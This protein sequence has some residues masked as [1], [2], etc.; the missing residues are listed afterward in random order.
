MI[1]AHSSADRAAPA[2]YRGLYKYLDN[3][4]A[5]TV[6]LTFEQIESLLGFA[7]PEL[8]RVAQDWWADGDANGVR[9]TQSKSWGDASRSATAN[10]LSRSVVFERLP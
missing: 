1:D 2:E 3:R 4:F 9:S 6:V 5:D 8:A 7:L 10:L